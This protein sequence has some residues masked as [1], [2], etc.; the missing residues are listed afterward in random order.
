MLRL[1]ALV[2]PRCTLL[3]E[4]RNLLINNENIFLELIFD[5]LEFLVMF[6]PQRNNLFLTLFPHLPDPLLPAFL[7]F[8]YPLTP[9]LLLPP[10]TLQH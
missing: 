4:P 5:P 2:L 10:L 1:L 3:P 9:V 6:L 8:S 7:H